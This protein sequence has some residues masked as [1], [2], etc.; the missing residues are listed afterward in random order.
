MLQTEIGEFARPGKTSPDHRSDPDALA[1]S[2][3]HGLAD[4]TDVTN[5]QNTA[6]SLVYRPMG[7]ALFGVIT[8]IL[9]AACDLIPFYDV[10]LAFTFDNRTDAILC[11]YPSSPDAAAGSCAAAIK[12]HGRTTWRLGCADEGSRGAVDRSPITLI[13]TV[14]ETGQE[15]YNRTASCK[16][17]N[18]SD[19]RFVIEEDGGRFIVTDSL[20]V[21]PS[22]P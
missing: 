10:E 8:A 17:W 21:S 22:G 13:I 12:P 1:T 3:S 7:V 9:F 5:P 16:E 18:D 15:I 11:E 2:V 6:V 4:T 19:R 20:A 14:K